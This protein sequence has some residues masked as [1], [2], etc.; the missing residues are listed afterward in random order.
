[1]VDRAPRNLARRMACI[2]RG[3]SKQNTFDKSFIG[4][5]RDERLKNILL[6]SHVDARLPSV[7]GR[8]TTTASTFAQHSATSRPPSPNRNRN[9]ES[10]LHKATTGTQTTPSSQKRTG[11]QFNGS[12]SFAENSCPATSLDGFLA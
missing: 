6:S 5:F 4:S 1:M 7:H 2:A 3:E 8:S 10:R 12:A 11:F 9:P